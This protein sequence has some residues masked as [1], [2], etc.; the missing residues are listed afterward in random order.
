M[1]PFSEW[2]FIHCSIKLPPYN[3]GV[4]QISRRDNEIDWGKKW[5]YLY[6]AWRHVQRVFNE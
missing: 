3:R 6:R 2:R 5:G 4:Y 1:M